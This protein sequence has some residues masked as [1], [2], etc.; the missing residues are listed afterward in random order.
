MNRLDELNNA[1]EERA[2]ILV[3]PLVERAPKVAKR[4]VRHRPFETPGDLIEVIKSELLTLNEAERID[5]FNAHP[6]LAPDSPITM[7][8]ESQS[9]QGRLDLTSH[10]NAYKTRL[11]E[12]NGRYRAKHGFPFITALVR[13]PNIDSVLSEFEERLVSDHDLEMQRAI[14]Q[15][16]MVSSARVQALFDSGDAACAPDLSS[17]QNNAQKERNPGP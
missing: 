6:E 5:L 15:I 11:S 17:S 8:N 4:I 12:L 1:D 3:T 16:V 13:H 10:D 9:E 2:I 14:D 7:T